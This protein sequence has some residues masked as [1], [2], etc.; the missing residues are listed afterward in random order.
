MALS[1]SLL[2]A[3]CTMHLEKFDTD[4]SQPT[5]AE[6]IPVALAL[7]LDSDVCE[8]EVSEK[9]Q[10]NKR[11]FHIGPTICENARAL[12]SLAF[13]RVVN[14]HNTGE[15]VA[16]TTDA[17]AHLKIIEASVVSRSGLPV[18]IDSIVVLEWSIT[19]MDGRILYANTLKGMGQDARTFGGAKSRLRASMESCLSDLMQK[20]YE[21]LSASPAVRRIPKVLK[22]T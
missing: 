22:S 6:K 14:V 18:V 10:G 12:F 5:N 3:G 7:V 2:A 20:L 13:D 15:V 1:A 17:V 8:F 11:I 9:R 4:W 19:D 21:D 16:T